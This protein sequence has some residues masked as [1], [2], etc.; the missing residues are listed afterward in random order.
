MQAALAYQIGN[1]TSPLRNGTLTSA[2]DVAASMSS[3]NSVQTVDV[4]FCASSSSWV[5][6]EQCTAD[7]RS[8]SIPTSGADAHTGLIAG[9]VVAAVVLLVVAAVAVRYRHGCSFTAT[10]KAPAGMPMTAIQPQVTP[11]PQQQPPAASW[12]GLVVN[13]HSPPASLAPAR[14]GSHFRVLSPD[15]AIGCSLN[16]GKEK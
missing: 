16:E 7:S 11:A 10:D 13:I 2:L 9:L 6:P 8:D 1:S 5:P 12:P 4:V 15:A 3:A 14:Q